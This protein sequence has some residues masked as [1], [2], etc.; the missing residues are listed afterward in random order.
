MYVSN[1]N[2]SD[3]DWCVTVAMVLLGCYRDRAALA[4]EMQR[5]TKT[6][7]YLPHSAW[8]CVDALCGD[9]V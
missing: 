4:V 2:L 3:V 5:F 9:W 8:G 6:G 1:S 7:M